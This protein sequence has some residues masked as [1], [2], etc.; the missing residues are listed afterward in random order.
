MTGKGRLYITSKDATELKGIKT[1]FTTQLAPKSQVQ[2]P[3]IYGFPTVEVVEVID[4]ETVKIKKMFSKD[5]VVQDLYEEGQK[6]EKGNAEGGLA[7]K[8][9]PYIDQTKV[10]LMPS[11]SAIIFS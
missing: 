11:C 5:K 8:C 4:D 7:Y 10:R 2:L 3:K 1:S 9:L 6:V